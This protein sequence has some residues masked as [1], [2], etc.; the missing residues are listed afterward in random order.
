MLFEIDQQTYSDLELK[1]K[2]KETKSIFSLFAFTKS[3]G[4]K[5]LLEDLFN[6]PLCDKTE[7]DN[8][9]ETIRYFQNHKL[10]IEIDKHRLNF[11]ELYFSQA[12]TPDRFLY[13]DPWFKW[14][15]NKLKPQNEFYIQQRGIAYLVELFKE[16]YHFSLSELDQKAP[17]TI[18]QF[19]NDLYIL[20]NDPFFQSIIQK[21]GKLRLSPHLHRKLDFYFR[22]REI[23]NVRKILNHF[24]YFDVYQSLALS[25]EH[26]GFS[27]PEICDDSN[28]YKVEGLFHPFLDDPVCNNLEFKPDERICFL[29]GPNMAGKSTFLKAVSISVYLAH[30][31]FPVPAK[32]LKISVFNG[33][34]TTINLSDNIKNGYSHFYNEILRIKYVAEKI[35]RLG[36]L[37]VVFDEL[38]RGT[39]VKDAYE[40][41]LA[42]INAFA[43]INSG[44]FA[45]STHIIEIAEKLNDNQARSYKYFE[46]NLVNESPNYN[47]LIKDGITQERIG[48]YLLKKENVIEIIENLS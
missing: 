34:L 46:A 41:S 14:L 9:I 10:A 23:S 37:F 19:Q 40:A 31:G 3:I 24:Y 11:I 1:P 42:V 33:L 30:I 22:K 29:T 27:L 4:G 13:I 6:L 20:F 7:I 15:K 44:C 26:H 48:M 47:Y 12:N 28:K 16:L 35:N 5:R 32:S 18:K 2:L 21:K 25:I 36:N 38:F 8:R 39:N 43:K 17:E 45:I